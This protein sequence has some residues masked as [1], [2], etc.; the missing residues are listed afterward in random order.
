VSAVDAQVEVADAAGLRSLV[1]RG[2]GW[3]L[4]SQVVLQ[5]SRIVIGVVLARL[6]TPHQFGLAGMVIVFSSFVLVFSDLALG[7]A[8]VQRRRLS[9]RDRSTVFWTAAAAGAVFTAGGI[10]L[11][12]PISR[13]YG[14]PAVRPLFAVLAVSF[15]VTSL[16]TTQRALLMREMN[17]KSLELRLM[18]GSIVAGVIGIAAA[19]MRYGAWAIILQQLT[20]AVVST[21]LLWRFSPWRPSFTFSLATL[22]RLGGFSGS[23]FGQRLLYYLHLSSATLLIGRVLGASALGAWSVAY[24][25]VFLPFAQLAVPIAEVLFPAFSR[26]QSDPRRLAETWV[27][28]TRLVAAISVPCLVGLALVARDFVHVALGEKWHVAVPVIQALAAVGIV[29]SLQTLNGNILQAVDRAGV[30]FRYTIW[31]FLVNLAGFAIGL[32]WGVVGVAVGYTVAS[33]FVEPAYNLITSRALGISAWVLPRSLGG[34]MQATALMACALVGARVLLVHAGAA[35]PV[36]LA[37]LVVLGAVVYLPAC[38]WRAP[39][40]RGELRQLRRR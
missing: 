21:I 30:L 26:L 5:S 36:R 17:F 27:R 16:G 4:L 9:E 31:F 40:L 7:A 12:Y 28:A 19:G 39:E 35:A 38:A 15:V 18:I 10:G 20:V 25:L 37:A 2:V 24:S 22:R 33:T 32:H 34:V 3:K 14:E 29:Q 8:L 1:L 11:A 23:V 6:L 13:F